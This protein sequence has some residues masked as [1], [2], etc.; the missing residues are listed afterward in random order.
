MEG[1]QYLGPELIFQPSLVKND[2]DE[3]ILSGCRS[4]QQITQD[5]ITKAEPKKKLYNNIVLAGGNTMF[6]NIGDRLESEIN[7]HAPDEFSKE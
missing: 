6:P 5:A 4:I 2:A 3:Q 7:T 1:E